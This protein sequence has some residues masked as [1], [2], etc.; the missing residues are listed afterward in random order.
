MANTYTLIE[1]KTIS[2][3]VANIT[4]SSIPATYTDLKIVFSARTSGSSDAFLIWF[5]GAAANLSSKNIQ[6]YGSSTVIS[7]GF[8]GISGGI[9]ASSYTANTFNNA[10]FYIPNYT[11]SNFKSIS[12]DS[13]PENNAVLTR[14]VLTAGLW[15]DTAAITSVTI[16]GNGDNLVQYSTFYLYGIKNS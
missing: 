7:G 5:N 2:T 12:L 10:E 11:T 14:Q 1:A 13:V 16:D 4:F 9:P 8:S 6:G 15:S 3:A